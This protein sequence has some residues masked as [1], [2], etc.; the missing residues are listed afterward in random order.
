MKKKISALLAVLVLVLIMFNYIYPIKLS[1][2]IP[3]FSYDRVEIHETFGDG[4]YTITDKEQV[5]RIYDHIANQKVKKMIS[6]FYTGLSTDD[7]AYMITF[8]GDD[9][10]IFELFLIGDDYITINKHDYI[11]IQ[12]EFDLKSFI[13]MMN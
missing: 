4:N 8:L 6:W 5:R 10:S 1:S 9:R 3:S 2:R 12:G 7:D 11:F 13:E